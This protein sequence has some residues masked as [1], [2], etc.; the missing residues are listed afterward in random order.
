[1]IE[2][3][4]PCSAVFTCKAAEVNPLRFLPR[5]IVLAVVALALGAFTGLPAAE[6]APAPS[7]KPRKAGLDPHGPVFTV[8]FPDAARARGISQGHAA[9]SVLVDGS[10]RP[11][12]FL[13]T[14]ETDAAFGRALVDELR[15]ATFQPATQQ[16]VPV[17]ARC[18]FSYEFTTQGATGL[19]VLDAVDSR[20]S[21]GKPKPTFAPVAEAKLDHP[22]EI[23]EGSVPTLPPDFP[24]TDKPVK[25]S[26]TFF[27][28]ET[29]QV[30]TPNIESAS[31]PQVFAA[32]I[33]ALA[34]W[35]CKP[36]TA[37]GK[38]ALVFAG[39]TFAV[40]RAPR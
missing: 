30:R 24:V 1:M 31:P 35:K 18:A 13:V 7:S 38:P 5:G 26:V 37:G 33:A 6:A 2:S 9:A 8:Q 25:V 16:G 29:G 28:D 15:T 23:I 11:V 14:S 39:R 17:P 36:P 12:D 27:V 4:R 21:L 22:L 34:T 10:G 3:S 40:P 19:T 20:T 32:V